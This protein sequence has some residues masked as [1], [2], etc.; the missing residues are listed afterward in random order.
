MPAKCYITP[1]GF[2]PYLMGVQAAETG[3]QT[4]EIG[5]KIAEV[6]QNFV[7]SGLG[8]WGCCRYFKNMQKIFFALFCWL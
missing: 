6:S 7:W 8:S 3:V 5:V 2:H 4:A 1:V